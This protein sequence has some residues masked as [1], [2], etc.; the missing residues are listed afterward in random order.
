MREV[1]EAVRQDQ[2]KEFASTY[3]W[4]LGIGVVI[5]LAAF[6]GYLFW[7][8]Q[9]ESAMERSSEQIVAAIDELDA[10]NLDVADDELAALMRDGSTGAVNTARLIRAGIAMQQ[11]RKDDAVALF[12]EVA[13]DAEVPQPMRDLAA[14]R[15]V[16]A[17]FD[18]MDPDAVIARIGPLATE[19]NPWFASAGELVAMAYLEQG[20]EEQAGPLLVAIAKN[21]D[22]P[23]SLRARTRQIAGLLGHDAV[24]DVE[25][26]L[27][28]MEQSADD[29]GQ[30]TA[31]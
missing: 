2:A 22:A 7:D 29:P 11:G 19:G 20:N 13:G 28:E 16:A 8:S 26:M 31:Q 14:I 18:E 5:G 21:E 23:A 17:Q 9:Q 30:G 3:G 25:E 12:D 10:G 1:D 24:E 6:G 15:S 4:P 27:E